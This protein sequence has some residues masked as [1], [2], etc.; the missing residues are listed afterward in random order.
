MATPSSLRERD[1]T[2]NEQLVERLM[3]EGDEEVAALAEAPDNDNNEDLEPY[4]FRED[5]WLAR[6]YFSD[7]F[8]ADVVARFEGHLDYWGDSGVGA[9][10]WAAYRAYHNI[11]GVDGDPLTQLQATGEYGELLAMAIPHYRTLVRHQI[12]MFTSNRPAWDPQAR[13]ADAEGARQVPMASNLL[14]YVASTGSL[15]PRLGEQVEL[16]MVA[17]E[18]F[19]VVGCECG[20]RWARLVHA[21]RVRPLGDGARADAHLRRRQLAHLPNL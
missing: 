14:D 9:T 17:G 1:A 10:T 3:A 16:M 13:T 2:L 7:E 5:F 12:S 15:D 21:A 4:D 20:A 6:P 19:F 11:S 18:G 8:A